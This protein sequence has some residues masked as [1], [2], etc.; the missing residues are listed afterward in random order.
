MC[1]LFVCTA[2]FTLNTYGQIKEIKY[3]LN[4]AT[5]KALSDKS[6]FVKVVH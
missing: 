2:G 6:L 5:K 3:L 1:G 4:F